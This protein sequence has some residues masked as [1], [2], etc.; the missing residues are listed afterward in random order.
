MSTVITRT[1]E[2]CFSLVSKGDKEF[3]SSMLMS[4]GS[5]RVEI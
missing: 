2:R 3:R 4:A 5:G 1:M